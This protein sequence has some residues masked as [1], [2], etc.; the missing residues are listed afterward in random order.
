MSNDPMVERLI[1]LVVNEFRTHGGGKVDMNDPLSL[2]RR[3]KPPMFSAGVDVRAVVER[4]SDFVITM[5][6]LA[7]PIE[8]YHEDFGPVMW[9]RFPI[10]EPPYVGSPLDTGTPTEV[11]VRDASGRSE[12]LQLSLGGWPG[13]H[14]H[15]TPIYPPIH[16]AQVSAQAGGAKH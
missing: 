14:T 8:A 2:L 5:H 15:W 9:W 10:Q 3:D 1:G 4:L 13:Y 12:T 7:R 11:E 16:P 6:A